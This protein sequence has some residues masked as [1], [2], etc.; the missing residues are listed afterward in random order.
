MIFQEPVI[1]PSWSTFASSVSGIWKGVGAVFSPITAKMEPVGLGSQDEKLFDCYT[2]SHIEQVLPLSEGLTSQ[3]QRK[4]N[5][6]FLNPYGEMKQPSRGSG[7]TDETGKVGDG[8]SAEKES[9]HV[10]DAGRTLPS[11]ESFD[12]GTSDLLEED[13]MGMEPGLVFF[14]VGQL[15]LFLFQ[16]QLKSSHFLI[17][18]IAMEELCH[19]S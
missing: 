11:F 14:E 6:V 10:I 19:D 13:L 7:R 5:W 16:L 17:L 2:L 15:P 12:F 3:I 1:R 9:T 18:Y 8:S 4:I